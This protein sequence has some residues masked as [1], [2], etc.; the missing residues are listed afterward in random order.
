MC[1]LLHFFL[2][3]LAEISEALSTLSHPEQLNHINFNDNTH[4]WRLG[5]R[6]EPFSVSV[7]E[8]KA[9]DERQGL[10]V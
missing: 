1:V 5:S 3:I 8:K 2:N 10:C 9:R 7:C 4:Q 6:A